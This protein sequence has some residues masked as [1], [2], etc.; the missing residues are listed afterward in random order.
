[1]LLNFTLSN[2]MSYRDEASLSMISSLER[3]HGETRSGASG[4]S[5]QKR[6]SQLLPCT[7]ATLPE[8]PPS[9]RDSAALREMVLTDP[10]VDGL[11]PIQPFMLDSQSETS[12]TL[13][14]VTFLA[15]NTTYRLVVEATRFSVSYESLEIVKEDKTIDV[16]ERDASRDDR[17]RLNRELFSDPDHV[18]YAAKSTR[19]NQCFSRCGILPER[20]RAERAVRVVRRYP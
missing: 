1:M 3:R 13:F 4:L 12:P 8:R 5:E 2:W 9:S 14:D 17:F 6:S 15:G 16:Y 7:A 18:L 10:G 11:L 19:D 20:R